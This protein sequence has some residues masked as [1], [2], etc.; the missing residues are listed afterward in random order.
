M[1]YMKVI[2]YQTFVFF[3]A[4][5]SSASEKSAKYGIVR[6]F[7]DVD[8]TCCVRWFSINGEDLG[9]EDDVSVY[10]LVA[11]EN[12]DFSP[13]ELVIAINLEIRPPN[14]SAAG[15]VDLGSV[16]I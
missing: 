9:P 6:T 12:M 5:R 7:S 3:I 16:L 2:D 13:G 1:Y 14:Y 4:G 15:K 11:H 8:R 10:D